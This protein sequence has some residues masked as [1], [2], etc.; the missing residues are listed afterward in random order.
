[1]QAM[2]KWT[3]NALA[4]LLT[5]AALMWFSWKTVPMEVVRFEVANQR[6]IWFERTVFVDFSAEWVIEISGPDGETLCRGAGKSL[7]TADESKVKRWSIGRFGDCP[8]VVPAGSV[9]A[10]HWSP[11]DDRMEPVKARA[12]V[13]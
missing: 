4:A 7:F 3:V 6:V 9:V 1:M 13:R 10:A 12:V 2:V 8:D 5:L 11:M